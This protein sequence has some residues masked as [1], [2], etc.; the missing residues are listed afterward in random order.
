[1]STLALSVPAHDRRWLH[2]A[3][4]DL[5]FIVG[6]LALA[7]GSG[8]IVVAFPQL[9]WWIVVVDLWVLGYH[10]VVS[11]YTRLCFDR[12]SLKSHPFLV[13]GLLPIIALVVFA[14][15]MTVGLWIVVTVYF[16][17]QWFHYAR[18]NW[19]IS[20]AYR[21]KDP[22][23]LYED[24]WADQAIFY[25]LPV[26]GVVYRSDQN[27]GEF[28]GLPLVVLA[29]PHW[30]TIVCA[31][32]TAVLLAYWVVRRVQAWRSGRLAVVHTLYM[33]CHF[34]IFAIGYLIIDDISFG[35]L[36]IN[37]WHNAQYIM[38]VWLFNAR[39]FKNGID[40]RARFLS[41]ISQ[42]GRLGLYVLT[43]LAITGVIYWG[44]IGTLNSLFLAGIASTIVFY[45][46]INFHHYIVDAL[47]WKLRAGPVRQTMGLAS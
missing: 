30:L 46:V 11:T 24:R 28:L 20:R 5:V 25:A 36:A 39:R 41:Y 10:H 2:D 17:W 13:F 7:S 45:Q 26:L 43:C 29:V 31:V 4:F 18:Q 23:A 32:L 34:A 14:A 44:V 33:T 37:M 47:V 3:R 1:M 22:D 16:Y 27:P 38:F 35:W 19:G 12:Q 15:G 21:G 8:A 9:F 6:V 40:P 42:P